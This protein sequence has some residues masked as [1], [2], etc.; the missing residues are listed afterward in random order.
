VATG[1]L[2]PKKIIKRLKIVESFIESGNRPEWMVLTVIPVIPPELRPLVPLDV[3]RFVTSDLNDLY[4]RV[5]NR[6]NRL[7]RLIELCAPDIILR[8]EKRMLQESVDALFDNNRSRNKTK[9]S[10]PRIGAEEYIDSLKEKNTTGFRPNGIEQSTGTRR[11]SK[12]YKPKTDDRVTRRSLVLSER[13]AD[14]IKRTASEQGVSQQDWMRTLLENGISGTP[15]LAST[16]RGSSPRKF[17]FSGLSTSAKSP[18]TK[19]SLRLEHEL[20]AA[21]EA[22]VREANVAKNDWLRAAIVK[23]L[24][25]GLSV[26][27]LLEPSVAERTKLEK[28]EPEKT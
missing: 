23:A 18:K 15:G 16:A 17:T 2:K 22:A 28:P 9:T 25:E 19:V 3:G 24:V 21:V 10:G 27:S 20:S 1:E 4:R 26:V 13:L 12:Y 6:N 8:N 5:I 7:R 11:V 14:E